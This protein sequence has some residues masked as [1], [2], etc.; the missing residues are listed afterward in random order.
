MPKSNFERMIQLAEDVFAVK[1]DPSQLDVNEKVIQH[2]LKIHPNSVSEYDDGNGPVAWI[3]LIP[4]TIGLMNKFLQK[5]ISE[6]QLYELT[7]LNGKYEAIYLCSGLVLEEY[8]R[9]G[10]AKKLTLNAIENIRKTHSIEV[11]FVWTFSEEGNVAAQ[12]I[13][14]ICG[15]PLFKLED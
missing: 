11:L 15:M 7:P 6:K 4:T 9:A 8:R 2:L 3:L 10:I 1:N 12:N 13:S 5:E 14:K